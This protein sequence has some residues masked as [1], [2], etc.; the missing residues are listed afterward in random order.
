M[1][2]IPKWK[3]EFFL[4][5]KQVRNQLR[6]KQRDHENRFLYI[7]TFL[8][9]HFT[10]MAYEFCFGYT[11]ASMFGIIVFHGDQRSVLVQVK[12]STYAKIQINFNWLGSIDFLWDWVDRFKNR[13]TF[14]LVW[15][16]VTCLINRFN[17]IIVLKYYVYVLKP[18][19]NSNQPE[20]V[21]G[22]LYFSKCSIG[23]VMHSNVRNR[24]T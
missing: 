15:F 8:F 17:L 4:F 22:C 16:L 12:W 2:S 5:F 9:Y 3:D 1:P 24:F 14:N 19:I 11:S 21:W 6:T 18:S 13:T 23:T 20:N 7:I 10:N